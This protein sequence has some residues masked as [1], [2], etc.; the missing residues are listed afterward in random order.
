MVVPE[1][2]VEDVA[3]GGNVTAD[4]ADGMAYLSAN[5]T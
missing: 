3:A 5:A 2:D 4:A 1:N